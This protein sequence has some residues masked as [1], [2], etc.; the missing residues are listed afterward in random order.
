MLSLS[1]AMA[2]IALLGW[3][4]HR[5]HLKTRVVKLTDKTVEQ[6]TA[7]ITALRDQVHALDVEVSKVKGSSARAQLTASSGR[8]AVR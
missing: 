2:F 8:R 7:T 4:A 3:H 5:H 1:I 6:M